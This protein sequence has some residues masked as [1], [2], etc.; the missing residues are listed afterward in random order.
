M[1][2]NPDTLYDDLYVLT[3]QQIE[4]GLVAGKWADHERQIVENYLDRLRL[5]EDKAA[6]AE[7]LQISN[8]KVLT[9]LGAAKRA[10]FL[11]TAALILSA[12]AMLA[13][14]TMAVLLYLALAH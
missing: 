8:Q 5:E 2:I 13:I 1:T 7:Q 12:G 11:A 10:E 6:L 3:E 4:I 14:I 9:A